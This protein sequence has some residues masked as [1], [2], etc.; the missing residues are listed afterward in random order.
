MG[1]RWIVNLVNVL[2]QEVHMIYLSDRYNNDYN[3]VRIKHVL[4]A[5]PIVLS[6]LMTVVLFLTT[7]LIH[8][9]WGHFIAM[10][11]YLSI[12]GAILPALLLGTTGV[13]ALYRRRGIPLFSK[14]NWPFAVLIFSFPLIA[15]MSTVNKGL[16]PL[17]VSIVGLS[18]VFATLNGVLEELLWRGVYPAVFKTSYWGAVVM[19]AIGYALWHIPAFVVFPPASMQ[20][21]GIGLVVFAFLFGMVLGSVVWR[22]QSLWLPTGIHIVMGL[23]AIPGAMYL[24]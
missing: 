16:P 6:I 24:T 8:D 1:L 14:R 21:E 3:A 4:I 5:T 11:I 17:T 22:T 19:P 7:A 12:G 23:I 2:V 18:I 10:L 15:V 13:R 9:K 20:G